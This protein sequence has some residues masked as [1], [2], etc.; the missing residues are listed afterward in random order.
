MN[1][2][3]DSTAFLVSNGSSDPW[4]K[5]ASILKALSVTLRVTG[6]SKEDPGLIHAANWI[7]SQLESFTFSAL[8]LQ[9]ISSPVTPVKDN[10]SQIRN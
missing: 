8:E 3:V 6:E 9:C 7:E 1:D 10:Q 2:L 4:A 5:S